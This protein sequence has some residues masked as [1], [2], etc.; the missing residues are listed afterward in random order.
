MICAF[1]AGE[2]LRPSVESALAQTHAELEVMVVDDGSRD[3]SVDAIADLER[4]PRLRVLRQ[5]RNEGKSA[6]LNRALDELG[7]EFYAIQDADDLSA[8]TR[9]ERQLR[10]FLADPGLAAVLCGH[11]LILDGRR[12][13]PTFPAKDPERCRRDVAAMRMP[14][15]DPTAMYRVSAVRGLRYDVGLVL[16]EGLDYILQ[17]GEAHPIATLGECLYAYRV[18]PGSITRRRFDERATSLDRV[19]RRAHARRGL[20]PPPQAAPPGPPRARDRDNNLA[21][22]FIDSALDLRRLGRRADALRTGI[23]CS[24]LHPADPHYHKALAYSLAPAPLVRRLSR[25]GAELGPSRASGRRATMT[26]S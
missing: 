15:H 18:N 23:A 26:G 20:A 3:G 6:A 8:P 16:N 17:V 24:R 7:G 5:P 25:A 1:D 14:A 2:H 9:I 11:E 4:D 12:V 10:P 21:A 19:R 13:A 22:F